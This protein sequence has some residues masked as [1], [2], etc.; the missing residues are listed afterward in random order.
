[1]GGSPA[2]PPIRRRTPAR[3]S[4]RRA[5]GIATHVTGARL[6][7]R[8]RAL[9]LSSSTHAARA[10]GAVRED[11]ETSGRKMRRQPH[12]SACRANCRSAR[13]SQHRVNSQRATNRCCTLRRALEHS[14][15]YA[16]RS[17]DSRRCR[18]SSVRIHHLVPTVT[19][20]LVARPTAHNFS[21]LCLGARPKPPV[22][23]DGGRSGSERGRSECASVPRGITPLFLGF[24]LEG[25]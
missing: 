3:I 24:L 5:L 17:P 6:R 9:L 7:R 23:G 1:M 14:A 11:Q 21:A 13:L 4:P 20:P 18:C 25:G 2:L 22:L 16:G 10:H 15:D 19:L 8:A 12:L